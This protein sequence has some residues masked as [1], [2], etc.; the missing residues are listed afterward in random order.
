[1]TDEP[2]QSNNSS[3]I[4]FNPSPG[5]TQETFSDFCRE[6]Y[7]R[8]AAN[9]ASRPVLLEQLRA[10]F[11]SVETPLTNDLVDLHFAQSVL[12]DMIGLGWNLEFVGTEMRLSLP[13]KPVKALSRD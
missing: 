5:K 1:M 4:Q 6:I 3:V 11:I 8:L 7:R 13:R 12:L 9:G 2:I 10:E